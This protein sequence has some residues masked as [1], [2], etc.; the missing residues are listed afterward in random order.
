MPLRNRKPDP[1]PCHRVAL[2]ITGSVNQLGQAQAI[3]A[4]NEKIEGFFDVCAARGLSGAQ[5]V[6]IPASNVKHLMLRR[7]VVAAAQA[8]QFHVYS[9]ENVDQAI[10]LLTGVAAGQADDNGQYPTGSINERVATRVAELN[11][12]RKTFGRTPAAGAAV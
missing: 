10:A 3:G 8:G 2:A 1:E 12:L 5:G 9:V 6:L 4:V 7:D 11:E